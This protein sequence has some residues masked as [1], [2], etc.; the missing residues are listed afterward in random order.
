[1][2]LKTNSI[3]SNNLDNKI[4]YPEPISY[5]DA[6]YR[7]TDKNKILGGDN[8][9]LFA[10]N[11]IYKIKHKNSKLREFFAGNTP[12]LKNRLYTILD[13]AK[14][15]TRDYIEDI[16]TI[17]IPTN[18]ELELFKSMSITAINTYVN[19]NITPRFSSIF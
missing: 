13:I 12:N 19:T 10:D 2:F 17:G 16:P 8:V 18:H 11:N 9:M 15:P 1:M 6:I 5:E 14:K 4:I 3:P 7:L